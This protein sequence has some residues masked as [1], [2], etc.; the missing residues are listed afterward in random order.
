MMNIVIVHDQC[1]CHS[2]VEYRLF[3]TDGITDFNTNLMI[4][5]N[6]SCINEIMSSEKCNDRMFLKSYVH[7]VFAIPQTQDADFPTAQKE[8]RKKKS[9]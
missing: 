7:S 2:E 4:K 9:F 6:I 5:F 8:E 1:I 3:K